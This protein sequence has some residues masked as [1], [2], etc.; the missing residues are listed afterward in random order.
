MKIIERAKF[1]SP[2]QTMLVALQHMT[3]RWGVHVTVR[4]K[5]K[6][7]L[8]SGFTGLDAKEAPIRENYAWALKQAEAKG[9]TRATRGGGHCSVI[10][11]GVPAPGGGKPNAAA[12]PDLAAVSRILER[13]RQATRKA[14]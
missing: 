6:K 4:D 14:S 1:V 2:G 5:D 8:T 10:L 11:P 9:W 7:I 13:G 12:D 3:D